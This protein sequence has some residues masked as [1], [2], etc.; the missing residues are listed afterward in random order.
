MVEKLSEIVSDLKAD[1]P[2]VFLGAQVAFGLF[3][4]YKTAKLIIRHSK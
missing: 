1:Y 2:D 3:A 4:T